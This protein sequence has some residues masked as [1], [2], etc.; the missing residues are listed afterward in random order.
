MKKFTLLFSVL[1][2]VA[3]TVKSQVEVTGGTGLYQ[4]VAEANLFANTATGSGI[5]TVQCDG[6]F[7]FDPTATDGNLDDMAS[8]ASSD[9]SIIDGINDKAISLKAHNWLKIWHGIPVNGGGSYVNDFTVVI[10]VRVANADG[11]YSLIEV[12]PTPATNGFTSELEIVGLQVGSVGAPSSSYDG[13]GF[14]T[15]TLLVD[16]WYRITYVAKLSEYIKVYVDGVLWHSMDG[17]FT[18]SRPAPYSADDHSADAAFK[19]GGNNEQAPANDPARDGD[20]DIDLIAVFASALTD[21]EVAGLG[22]SGQ[23]TSIKDL[24]L[25]ETKV[26][27]YPNP[28]SNILNIEGT[29]N[30]QL[31]NIIGQVVKQGTVEGSAGISV[32]RMNSGVYLLKF[33]NKKGN[34]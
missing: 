1:V 23:I 17:D 24:M 16:T 4:F 12:N 15:N 33:T 14:S 19:I 28:V 20:K 32:N 21:A 6:V 5:G 22:T 30:Y 10:D 29:G 31:I 26:N 8:N 34:S 25:Q 11:I 7:K 3:F 18:D 13:L 2:L 9:Y 27:F